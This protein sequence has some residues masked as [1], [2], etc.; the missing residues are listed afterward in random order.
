[1]P[2]VKL[3]PVVKKGKIFINDKPYR[4]ALVDPSS[5][6]LTDNNAMAEE[7][8]FITLFR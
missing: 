2:T 4:H 3:E 1:M 6:L 5:S 8:G 7:D